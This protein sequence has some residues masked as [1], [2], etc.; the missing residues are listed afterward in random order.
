MQPGIRVTLHALLI[1]ACSVVSGCGRAS[2][3]I[4]D[5]ADQSPR[6]EPMRNVDASA[7]SDAAPPVSAAM[8]GGRGGSSGRA[9]RPV[10]VATEDPAD[11]DA[12]DGEDAGAPGDKPLSPGSW[13]EYGFDLRNSQVNPHER[14]LNAANVAGLKERWR[15]HMLDGA[16]ST[17]AV[18]DGVAYFGGWDGNVYAVDAITGEIQWQVRV[19]DQQVNDTPLVAGDRLY[20]AAGPN[21]VALAR[22]DGRTLFEALLDAH[23]ATM[24]WSSP[25]LVDDM[26]IIGVASFENGITFDPKFKG[27]VVALEAQTGEEI[28]RL[29]TTGEMGFGPCYGGP[30]ASVWSSAAIDAELG[31]AFIGTGQGFNTPASTC[32]DSLLAIDY[33]REQRGERI[34]WFVQ[35]TKDDI[36][37]AINPLG[38]DADV[39]AAPNLFEAG[40]RALVGA[41]DKGGSYRVFD[42]RTGELVWRANLELGP[43]WTFGGV[44]TTAAVERDTIY[45]A[46]NHL[47][48]AQYLSM[49]ERDP[50]D[51]SYLYALETATGRERWK[52]KLPALMAGSFAVANGLLYHSITN[53]MLY[54]R[55]LETGEAVWSTELESDPGAGPSV[56]DG[57][58]YVSAG[59]ML[60]GSPTAPGGFVSSFALN[61]TMLEQRE[62]RV[63]QLAPLDEAA[64]AQAL[65]TDSRS[66]ACRAC[67]CACDP[68]TAGHCSS[69]SLLDSC[70][71]SSC[72]RAEPGDAMRTCLAMN[73]DA[74]LLP[75]FVFDRAVEL[76]PCTLQCA[77]ACGG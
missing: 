35:Y 25:K 50:N 37:G 34:R 7:P 27:S 1:V 77:Q 52:V 71:R 40:G 66:D 56:V 26:I 31:L 9:T 62:S 63:D 61:D 42:R 21:L 11:T 48:S 54:A 14:V 74:K 59:M 58:V 17:P 4:V 44:T 67:I 20:V 3:K 8:S 23:A 6:S 46:S 73:C 43:V 19:T 51:F 60:N 41:G 68:T 47:A 36:F 16:T 2:P 64:C 30:G 10:S 18:T 70:L 22:A 32:S 53:R 75:S 45:V 65:A 38:P 12:R 49:G 57:R 5:G 15:L 69:C 29:Q 24:I 39:G 33:R 28:W 55:S 72:A 13:T 76:A